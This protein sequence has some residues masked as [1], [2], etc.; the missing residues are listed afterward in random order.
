MAT[1]WRWGWRLAVLSLW[2]L[3]FGTH[4]QTRTPV[5]KP[6]AK[7][8]NENLGAT[9]SRK[10]FTERVPISQP[11]PTEPRRYTICPIAGECWEAVGTPRR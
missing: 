11:P 8:P 2:P 10:P 7:V 9:P 1:I 4:I 6:V 3:A 5:S